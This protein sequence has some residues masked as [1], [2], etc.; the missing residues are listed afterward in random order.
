MANKRQEKVLKMI[1]FQEDSDWTVLG[2]YSARTR[3]A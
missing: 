3:V 1:S 2:G